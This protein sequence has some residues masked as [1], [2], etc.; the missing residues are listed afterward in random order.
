MKVRGAAPLLTYQHS[1]A[2]DEAIHDALEE[3]E[4]NLTTMFVTNLAAD[5]SPHIY[6]TVCCH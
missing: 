6:S 5:T 3:A 2:V 1:S 4:S